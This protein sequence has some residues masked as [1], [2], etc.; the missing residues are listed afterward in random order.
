MNG[1]P[2]TNGIQLPILRANK[3]TAVLWAIGPYG[4]VMEK[5]NE[6]AAGLTE[7]I[8]N[9]FKDPLEFAE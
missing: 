6:I 4:E 7:A 1:K 2:S 9:W 3:M 8:S 5:T